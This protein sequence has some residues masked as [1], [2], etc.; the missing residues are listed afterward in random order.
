MFRLDK[1][2]TEDDL[3]EVTDLLDK[4]YLLKTNDVLFL[5]V[6][7]NKGERLVDPNF[8]FL[9]GNQAGQQM[10][11]MRD[12]FQYVIQADSIVAFP[13]VGN[14]NLVGMTLYEAELKVAE[15]FDTY[16]DGTF[17]KLRIAN[18][19]VF[20]L[21]APGGNVIPL[22]NEN[23]SLIEVLA[24]AEGIEFGAR[25]QNIRL[26]RGQQVFL[27]D[28][29][30]IS[31]MR[32]SNLTVEPGDII[33]VEPWRRPWLESLRDVTPTLS[34]VSSVVTLIVVILSI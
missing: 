22:A 28:L 11:Q 21:G 12:I 32:K 13:M 4:N 5:D 7:T 29:S 25:A 24:L 8:E 16:Y 17:V 34:I 15:A 33:Y 19:R 2:F 3:S 9:Q 14:M 31:G 20:L 10:Q 23:T 18:R 1:E 6:F 30:T 26:I 27:I